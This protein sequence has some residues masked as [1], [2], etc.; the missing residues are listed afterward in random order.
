LVAEPL[1]WRPSPEMASSPS[2]TLH[3]KAREAL[4]SVFQVLDDTQTGFI[5]R[6][7]VAKFGTDF[8]ADWRPRDTAK[9][10]R[11]MDTD[12]DS[13]VGFGDF[14]TFFR[15]ILEQLFKL[16]TKNKT[17]QTLTHEEVLGISQSFQDA[18]MPPTKEKT[19]K[20]L[21]VLGTGD[22][23]MELFVDFMLVETLGAPRTPDEQRRALARLLGISSGPQ[24][25]G[26]TTKTKKGL[27]A[28]WRDTLL[29][30]QAIAPREFI[31]AHGLDVPVDK[32][33][34]QK[35]DEQAA[36]LYA[37]FNR[38]SSVGE[39]ILFQDLLSRQWL[40]DQAGP[41]SEFDIALMRVILRKRSL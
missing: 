6:K 26:Q 4:Q 33:M 34:A 14:E 5:D 16:L 37:E 9:L 13:R 21:Q 3:N 31:A 11:A 40:E 41:E 27:D 12:E 38:N 22:V 10:M 24:A 19:K 1:T 28:S 29:R 20:C 15:Q 30:I 36:A 39:Q 32:L 23:V 18:L 25:K 7:V 2:A 35:T 17:Q 8:K